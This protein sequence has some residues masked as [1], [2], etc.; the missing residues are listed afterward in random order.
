MDKNK[1]LTFADNP[2]LAIFDV[3]EEINDNFAKL[4]EALE[5]LKTDSVSVTNISDAQ[6]DLTPLQANFEALKASLDTVKEAIKA[7]PRSDFSK[8]EKLLD[9]IAKK[10]HPKMDMSH[11]EEMNALLENNFAKINKSMEQDIKVTVKLV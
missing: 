8:M 3:L 5:S 9:T 10:E 4:S 6:V 1:L 11:M 7:Q 2:N